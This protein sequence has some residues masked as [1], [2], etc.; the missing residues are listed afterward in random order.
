LAHAASTVL[1]SRF[2]IRTRLYAAAA[3]VNA[4]TTFAMLRCRTFLISA[5]VFSHPKHS[6]I[7]FRFRWLTA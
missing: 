7:R 3:K 4:Q 2:R 5:I 1:A 6:S